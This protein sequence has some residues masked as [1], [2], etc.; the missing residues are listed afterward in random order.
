MTPDDPDALIE[1]GADIRPPK[2][3][4]TVTLI[5][6]GTVLGLAGVGCAITVGFTPVTWTLL[7]LAVPLAFI[8]ALRIARA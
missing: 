6:A 8:P 3:D 7:G 5:A 4:H 2:R 1:F